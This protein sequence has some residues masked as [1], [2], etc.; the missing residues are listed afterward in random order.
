MKSVINQKLVK[1]NAMIG[2]YTSLGALGILAIGLFISFKAPDK[3]LFSLLALLIG[4]FLSQVGIYYGNRWNRKPRPDEV[5]DRSLKGMG[6]EFIIY[7]YVTPAAHLLLGP[8]GAWI[9]L[10][11]FQSGKIS[12]AKNRW[13][14]RGG[15]FTQWYMRVFGQEN[16]G[17]PDVD[18]AAETRAVTA[19]LDKL[20]PE[21]V[22]VPQINSALMFFH[23]DAK[24]EL[25]ESPL[26]AL[27][28]AILKDFL[29]EKA[30]EKPIGSLTLET[31][32]GV[33]PKAGKEEE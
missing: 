21:G 13:R 1:R 10:P 20:L 25:D 19:Y 29:K 23:P 31:I 9:L 24:L 3:I 17:R 6:R 33:L 2:Q 30:K 12:Y 22:E 16:L 26:P 18:A 14:I 15:G 27:T 28:P 11:Y 32:Q 4:F 5:I 7:H 8:A